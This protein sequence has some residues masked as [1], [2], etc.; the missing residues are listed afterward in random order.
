MTDSEKLD[1]CIEALRSIK[2]ATTHEWLQSQE[3]DHILMVIACAKDCRRHAI[4][5]LKKLGIKDA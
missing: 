5:A 4:N 1:I 2:S 3:I